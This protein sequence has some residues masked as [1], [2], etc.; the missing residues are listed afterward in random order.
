ME[1]SS[2]GD[3]PATPET[4]ARL[5][6]LEEKVRTLKKE[7][8]RGQVVDPLAGADV[9]KWRVADL[10]AELKRRHLIVG[11]KKAALVE[12]LA[13]DVASKAGGGTA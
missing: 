7:S 13:G 3:G 4:L 5:S 9:S 2:D 10:K 11:G 1:A 12:R 8:T 6:G